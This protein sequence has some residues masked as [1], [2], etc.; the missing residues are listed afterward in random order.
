[1]GIR[2]QENEMQVGNRVFGRIFVILF[3]LINY[4]ELFVNIKIV[5]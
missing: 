5:I 4:S 2:A 1:M 3:V